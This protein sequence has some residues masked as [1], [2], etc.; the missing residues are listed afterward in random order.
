MT[1]QEWFNTFRDKFEI[2]SGIISEMDVIEYG[3]LYSN[4]M[5]KE[6]FALHMD[7]LAELTS[8][9]WDGNANL[10][11]ETISEFISLLQNATLVDCYGGEGRGDDYWAVWKFIDNGEEYFVRFDG[12]YSSSAGAE[13]N[14]MEL[15]KPVETKITKYITF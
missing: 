5:H 6:P 10:E 7:D 14:K 12:W 3:D 1:S 4:F 11:V 2:V 15:V 8:I 9:I 13:F